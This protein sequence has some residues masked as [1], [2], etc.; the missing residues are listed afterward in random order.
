[1][2]TALVTVHLKPGIRDP[3]GNNTEKALHLLGFADVKSIHT[4]RVWTIELDVKS[5]EKA[6]EQV[7]KMCRR[8]LTNPV[9]HDYKIQVQE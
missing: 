5:K 6:R 9:I 7:E 1:M 4:T 8:L 2:V 3:E